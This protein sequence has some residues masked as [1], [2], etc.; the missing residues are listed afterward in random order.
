MFITV[1]TSTHS[2]ILTLVR[3]RRL[4]CCIPFA[5]HF[6]V[7]IA[8]SK[9]KYSKTRI[10]QVIRTLIKHNYVDACMFKHN[11]S[12]T[13]RLQPLYQTLYAS[14]SM[15]QSLLEKLIITQLLKAFITFYRP[16]IFITVFKN[17]W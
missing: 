12:Q 4:H 8:S 14:K 2:W 17:V 1:F 13:L 5:G 10:I 15:N 7:H 9:P 3:W 16:R 6:S 11:L